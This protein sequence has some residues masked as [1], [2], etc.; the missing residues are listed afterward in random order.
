MAAERLPLIGAVPERK[1]LKCDLGRTTETFV[2]VGRIV[3]QAISRAYPKL[4][5]AAMDY[6]TSHSQL[7]R[8]LANQDNQ[9]LSFQRLWSMPMAFRL[10]LAHLLLEDLQA[11]GAPVQ[12][13]TTWHFRR[14]A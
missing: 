11:A 12:G 5:A 10:E 9:H 14:T 8:Q 6:G 1:M 7:T 2:R 3:E 13:E 4:E